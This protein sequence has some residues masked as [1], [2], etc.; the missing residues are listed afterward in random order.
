ML[1]FL[2]KK[3]VPQAKQVLVRRKKLETLLE[4]RLSS[5]QSIQD[6]QVQIEES[7]TNAEVTPPS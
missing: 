6:I 4:R 5:L 3:L 2:Q 7:Q 1:Q